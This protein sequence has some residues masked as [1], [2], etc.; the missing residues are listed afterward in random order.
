MMP[1]GWNGEGVFA[2]YDAAGIE[3]AAPLVDCAAPPLAGG[4]ARDFTGLIGDEAATPAPERDDDVSAV[5]M[6]GDDAA[7]GDAADR[8]ARHYVSGG[9]QRGH[10]GRHC[11]TSAAIASR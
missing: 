4:A 6:A 2:R 11:S 8:L 1:S 10:A 5:P 7:P 3:A 9:A